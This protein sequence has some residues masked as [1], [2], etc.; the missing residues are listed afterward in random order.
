MYERSHR[1]HVAVTGTGIR[2]TEGQNIVIVQSDNG[3]VQRVAGEDLQANENADHR[4]SVATVG[5]PR[6]WTRGGPPAGMGRASGK[7]RRDVG[8]PAN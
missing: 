3:S 2:S 6:L 8:S 1:G 4:H 5:Y 7:Q